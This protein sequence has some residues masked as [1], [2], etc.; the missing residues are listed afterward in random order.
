MESFHV[1]PMFIQSS[2]T[3]SEQLFAAKNGENWGGLSLSLRQ[4]RPAGDD[5]SFQRYPNGVT[6]TDIDTDQGWLIFTLYQIVSKISQKKTPSQQ[7]TEDFLEV[8]NCHPLHTWYLTSKKVLPNLF[9]SS[10]NICFWEEQ[11]SPFA[12]YPAVGS[13]QTLGLVQC[14]A[15]KPT[16]IRF[17]S[18]PFVEGSWR[19]YNSNQNKSLNLYYSKKTPKNHVHWNCTMGHNNML[20]WLPSQS[21]TCVR[22]H[23]NLQPTS[24]ACATGG[25][26]IEDGQDFFLIRGGGGDLQTEKTRNF[27]EILK[28]QKLF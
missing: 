11:N 25:P 26:D 10:F 23:L 4:R 17:V 5:S 6:S 20:T 2:K 24:L 19:V 18:I 21:G 12:L 22:F 27:G 1:F 15:W 8:L 9:G 14:V 3:R 13:S 28:F 7:S 16:T